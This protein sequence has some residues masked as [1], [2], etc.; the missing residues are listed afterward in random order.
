MQNIVYGQYLQNVLGQETM[1]TFRLG[2][3][4]RSVYNP[5]ANPS[6]INAFATAAFR[7]GHSMIMGIPMIKDTVNGAESRYRLDI[8]L[9]LLRIF[10]AR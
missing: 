2:I 4:G 5:D 3:G 9:L 6:V 7:Y 10:N 8:S 1:N